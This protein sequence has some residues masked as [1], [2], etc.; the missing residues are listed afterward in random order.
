MKG[1]LAHWLRQGREEPSLSPVSALI[2]ILKTML[3]GEMN[4]CCLLVL[5]NCPQQFPGEISRA[6]EEWGR[7]GRSRQLTWPSILTQLGSQSRIPMKK[8]KEEEEKEEGKGGGRGRRTERKRRRR[9]R[10][11]KRRRRKRRRRRKKKKTIF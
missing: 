5:P 11:R 10:K 9:G 7:E 4:D 2:H 3:P 8:K 6:T 1:D